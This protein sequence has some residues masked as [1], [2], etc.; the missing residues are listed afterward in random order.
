MGRTENNRI[1]NFPGGPA[2][3]ALVG[4]MLDVRVTQAMSHTLRGELLPR[5]TALKAC[6]ESPWEATKYAQ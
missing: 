3:Q 1:I 5:A 6:D 4:R 2:G